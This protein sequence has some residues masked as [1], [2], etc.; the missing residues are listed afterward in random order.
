M[1]RN[2]LDMCRTCL[3]CE[4]REYLHSTRPQA[5]CLNTSHHAL[6]KSADYLM[7]FFDCDYGAKPITHQYWTTTQ[8]FAMPHLIY[9]MVAGVTAV[10]FTVAAVAVQTAGCDLNPTARG[11]LAS[12][13]AMMKIKV[14][15]L[16]DRE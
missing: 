6:L 15:S 3:E 13:A 2:L 9:L 8:C 11:L 14:R 12:P 10:V 16:M 7:F 4:V 1:N 5:D